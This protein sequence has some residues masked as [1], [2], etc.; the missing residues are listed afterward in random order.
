MRLPA[1]VLFDMDGLL[2]DTEPIWTVAEVELARQ[3]GGEAEL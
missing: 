3:L 1:A 2:V